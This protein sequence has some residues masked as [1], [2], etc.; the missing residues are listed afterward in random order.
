[1][2]KL[3]SLM[4]A[5]V[6]IMGIMAG[7]GSNNETSENGGSDN[8]GNETASSSEEVTKIS[9]MYQGLEP[10]QKAMNYIVEKFK[11]E[12]GIDVELIYAPHDT[13]QE[14]L[15]GSIAANN[16]PTIFML[17]GPFLPNLV[18][19]GVAAE[20]N[21]YIDQS[22]LD[23]MTASNIAQCTYPIDGRL[24]A[25]GHQD[26]T[27]VLYGNKTYLDKIGARIPTSVED[28]WTVDEFEGYL[29]ALS[30]L[31]EVTFPLD[32]MRAYGV[33]SEWGTYGFYPALISGGGGIVNRE[34]WQAE[35][36][37]NGQ[38]TIEV[39]QKFQNWSNNGW[40][41]PE[42]AGDNMMYNETRDAALAWCG[43]WFFPA[44]EAALGDDLIVMPLPDFGNGVKSPNATWIYAIANESTEAEKVAAGKF[45][46][47][48]LQDDEFLR[49]YLEEV[50]SFPALK[51]WIATSDLFST[52]KMKIASEQS[53]STAVV[54]VPHPAYPIIT[55]SFMK[56]FGN[57]L[58]GADIKTELDKAAAEID[59]DIEDND[60]YP[61]FGGQ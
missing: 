33:K 31:D 35:G 12:T 23:D 20:I 37:L 59:E 14:Q 45:L 19:S 29:Q 53:A 38:S 54:R 4:M 7:C 51:S 43:T 28:A 40:L 27:V 60:G 9:F 39:L 34:T 3:L 46:S 44:A 10:E 52:G 58:D 6:M 47:Y 42:N 15:S 24:Y 57:I 49:I 8:E 50:G 1:M 36:M 32:I 41:V 55:A 25:V 17:D 61:P 16:V 48:M 26:S 5:L 21:Q 22:L 2:K 11:A 18:W 56:A 13:F 30:E